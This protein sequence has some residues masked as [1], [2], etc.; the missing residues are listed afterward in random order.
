MA[1]GTCRSARSLPPKPLTIIISIMHY[2]HDTVAEHELN[3]HIALGVQVAAADWDH[4]SRSWNLALR[5]TQE[6]GAKTERRLRCSMLYMCSGYFSYDTPHDPKFP[7]F[8]KFKGDTLFPQFWPNPC[9]SLQDK[10][11]TKHT[12]G[13]RPYHSVSWTASRLLLWV[14]APQR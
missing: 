2:L 4:D 10:Q 3:K 7:G 5:I 9:P 8:D 6:N 14:Q 12:Q 1:Q 11:V 13:A